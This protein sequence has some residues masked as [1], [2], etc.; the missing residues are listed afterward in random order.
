M[1]IPSCCFWMMKTNMKEMMKL[2]TVRMCT[3]PPEPPE[4][5]IPSKKPFKVDV[6]GGKR[7]SWCSCGH[8]RKQPFCDGAHR[9]QAPGLS[10]LRFVP[11]RDATL[12]LCGC[13]RTRT[14]PHCDGSHK[15]DLVVSAALHRPA[16]DA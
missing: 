6:I 13:K 7:Y 9:S 14:P 12:W 3:L 11:E 1:T 8:S 5:V 4:P 15:L 2:L 10:P 16:E